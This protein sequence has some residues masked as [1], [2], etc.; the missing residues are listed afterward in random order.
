M[1]F[2]DIIAQCRSKIA[3]FNYKLPPYEY[4]MKKKP[5]LCRPSSLY[6]RK[7]TQYVNF[8]KSS[9]VINFKLFLSSDQFDGIE[10]F[11]AY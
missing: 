4:L 10:C 11:D 6:L 2:S 8:L 7:S 3:V 1:W 5:N 9:L